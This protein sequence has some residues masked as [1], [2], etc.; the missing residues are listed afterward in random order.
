MRDFYD[1]YVLA[2]IHGNN[3]ND[4]IMQ[5]AL[6]AT[7]K[8]RGTQHLLIAAE[9]VFIDVQES[10]RMQQL[11]SAYQKKFSYANELEWEEAMKAVRDIYQR[12]K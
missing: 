3:L 1:V 8:K 5:E 4:L 2:K 10:E 12:M 11:W 6:D 7:S 9:D